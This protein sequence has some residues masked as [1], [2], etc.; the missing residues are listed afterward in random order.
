MVD[1]GSGG[2]PGP[3]ALAQAVEGGLPV[4]GVVIL[5]GTGD[6]PPRT[7]GSEARA[8]ARAVPGRR[9][10]F[11]R[12]RAAARE[13]LVKAGGPAAEIG[14]GPGREPLWP[15]GWIGSI[16]HCRDLV[17][18]VVAPASSAAGLGLDAEPDLPLPIDVVGSVMDRTEEA[19]A[20]ASAMPLVAVFCAKEAVHKAVFPTTRVWMDFTDVRVHF[21]EGGS[22][23]V[24][25]VPGRT[26]AQGVGRLRGRIVRGGGWVLA[27]TVLPRE[28]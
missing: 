21:A 28:R 27:V 1:E 25:P 6:P 11:A 7:L 5:R 15:A 4:G 8:V 18:A 22:F 19:S 10:E 16:T 2:G 13:A 17:G 26:V 23:R 9:E 24:E 12:G 14:V 3:E 20:A